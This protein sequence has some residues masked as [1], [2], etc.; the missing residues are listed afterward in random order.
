MS[1]KD[2]S[3]MIVCWAA[4]KILPKNG[5]RDTVSKTSKLKNLSIEKGKNGPMKLR[6]LNSIAVANSFFSCDEQLK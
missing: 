6:R 5:M 4:Q 1:K 2:K 3:Q